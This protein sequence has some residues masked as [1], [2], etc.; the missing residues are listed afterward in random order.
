[1]K[2][3]TNCSLTNH[4]YIHLNVCKQMSDIKLFMLYSKKIE[5][6]SGSFKNVI[7]KICLQIIYTG[8]GIK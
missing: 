5:M 4:M 6:T 2:L 8:F 3:P 7:Y 1:M